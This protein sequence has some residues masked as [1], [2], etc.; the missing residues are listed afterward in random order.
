M[1]QMGEVRQCHLPFTQGFSFQKT[2]HSDCTPF[3]FLLAWEQEL[4]ESSGSLLRATS[5]FTQ[6][7]QHVGEK[8][9]FQGDFLEC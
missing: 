2:V 7:A 9:A 5:L 1:L 4:A 3:A 6:Q 8:G